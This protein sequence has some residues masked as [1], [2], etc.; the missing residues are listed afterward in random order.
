MPDL[1]AVNSINQIQQGLILLLNNAAFGGG[2]GNDYEISS[3]HLL[4]FKK[5]A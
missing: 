5:Y 4:Y 1:P 2:G 3:K